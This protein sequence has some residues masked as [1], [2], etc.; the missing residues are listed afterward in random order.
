MTYVS[1]S[2]DFGGTLTNW[3]DS[4][5]LWGGYWMGTQIAPRIK[6]E[7]D[8]EALTKRTN[9]LLVSARLKDMTRTRRPWPLQT[10][11][12]LDHRN[13]DYA[14]ELIGLKMQQGKGG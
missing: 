7:I 11:T 14:L 2:T 5:T 8:M 13:L 6:N 4:F 1:S 9:D 10:I 3:P 12:D